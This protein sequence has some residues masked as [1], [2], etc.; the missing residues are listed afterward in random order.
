M[1]IGFGNRPV[2][3]LKCV[4]VWDLKAR[5]VDDSICCEN[6][7]R[8]FNVNWTGRPNF[9]KGGHVI[10]LVD[11]RG[12]LPECVEIPCFQRCQHVANPRVVLQ[13]PHRREAQRLNVS[14]R[15]A[16]SNLLRTVM[17]IFHPVELANRNLCEAN[18]SAGARLQY[19]LCKYLLGAIFSGAVKHKRNPC[20]RSVFVAAAI[21]KLLTCSRVRRN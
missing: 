14:S 7:D 1:P 4:D 3:S 8:L 13:V 18:S 15:K 5:R 17:A 10:I 16:Y 6:P 9:L 21:S 2:Y 11:K 19:S 12:Q 20:R